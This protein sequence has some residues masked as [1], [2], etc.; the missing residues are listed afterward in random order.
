MRRNGP[1]RR[2]LRPGGVKCG[3]VL[4]RGRRLRVG[5]RAGGPD[6]IVRGGRARHRLGGGEGKRPVLSGSGKVDRCN[7]KVHVASPGSVK[8]CLTEKMHLSSDLACLDIWST[9]HQGNIHRTLSEDGGPRSGANERLY[10]NSRE[11]GID[12]VVLSVRSA[13]SIWRAGCHPRRDDP[14]GPLVQESSVELDGLA[15][16]R[17]RVPFLFDRG[18]EAGTSS[19]GESLRCGA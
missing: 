16:R 4:S 5:L 17:R 11:G 13:A 3:L 9:C 2:E 7:R 15:D 19:C 8:N 6:G 10:N 18:V 12:E 14:G 1:G